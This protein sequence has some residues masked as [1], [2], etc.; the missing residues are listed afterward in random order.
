[1][2]NDSTLDIM[3]GVVAGA[4]RR[5]LQANGDSKSLVS[6]DL[7]LRAAIPV[8]MRSSKTM[9]TTTSNQFSSLMIDL[10]VGEVNVHERLRK[11]VC[12]TKEAKQSLEKIFVYL[13]GHVIGTLP[14]FL[15]KPIVKLTTSRVSIAITN[16]RGPPVMLC[17]SRSC[18][19]IS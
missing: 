12:S 9:I 15:V 8:D 5:V 16:V 14:E 4:M 13:C 7:C 11:L 10:P 17:T 2:T 3:L 19:S 18:S 1:M 6:K